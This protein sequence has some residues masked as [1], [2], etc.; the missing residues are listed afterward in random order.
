MIPEESIERAALGFRWGTRVSGAAIL[1]EGVRGSVI[2]K[3]EGES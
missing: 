3:E 1:P 2:R